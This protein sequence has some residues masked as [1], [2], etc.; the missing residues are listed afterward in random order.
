[1]RRNARKGVEG[2]KREWE[3]FEREKIILLKKKI[4]K[5]KK[6]HKKNQ[7]L[8]NFEKGTS[9][10]NLLINITRGIICPIWKI[11]CKNLHPVL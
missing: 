7:H 3:I 5:I 8:P 1:M 10:L 9:K 11:N 6:G 4:R 2:I